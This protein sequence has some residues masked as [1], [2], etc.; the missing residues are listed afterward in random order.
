MRRPLLLLLLLLATP[1][2]ADL[3]ALR[4]LQSGS[5]F[6][7]MAMHERGI[8]GSGEIVAVVD[9]GADVDSCAFAEL[10]GSLPPANTGSPAG[11]L[12]TANVDLSRR[13]VVAYDFLFSC[14]QYP[15][16]AGCDDPADPR[17]WDNSGHGT[18]VAS[19]AAGDRAPLGIAAEGD[20]LA[21][22]AKLIVQDLGYV[23]T[24]PCSVPGLGCPPSDLAPI[25]DQA[26]RQGAR[27]QTQEWGDRTGAYSALSGQLDA[28]VASHPDFVLV[29]NAGNA[30]ETG[31]SSVT[32][33]GLAKN[34]IQA[35]GT[36]EMNFDDSVVWEK[37]GRGPAQ[38]GRIKPDL[39]VPSYIYG[40]TS[41]G[42]VD[43]PS[44][45][46]IYTV[47]TSWSAPLVAGAAAL[48]RQYYREGFYPT[49]SAR[50][51]DALE[52]SAALVKATLIAAARPVPYLVRNGVRV[53]A[54]PA[55]SYDQG[56]GMPVL[57][58]VLSFDARAP[59][60]RAVDGTPGL[61]AGETYEVSV[62]SARAGRL[63]ATL[64]W[65]DPAGAELVND[66][67]VELIGPAGAR[68]VGNGA[69]TGGAFDRA[70]TVEKAEV[71]ASA[72]GTWTV[73]VRGHRVTAGQRQPFALVVAGDLIPDSRRRLVA[74]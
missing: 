67:D 44:C 13:K 37:S 56:F 2:I 8:D 70:N 38:G 30:G 60:M 34:T 29:F 17:A 20:G 11:G 16:R 9:T 33:P 12:A 53:E 46:G 72:A 58:D 54:G 42:R 62:R 7:S 31:P 6:G 49:G 26:Y 41:N 19:I 32:G 51:R 71:V 48:V 22:G 55:P 5:G 61:A 3:T 66:L 35:G 43:V 27:I 63:S 74:R 52:P 47:G 45:E 23:P 18:I 4:V 50:A 15:G 65:T 24:S 36:R 64:V 39:V 10:D 14:D 73:R 40:S 28:F 59:R 21:P 25:L 69:L 57:A 1:L 68:A